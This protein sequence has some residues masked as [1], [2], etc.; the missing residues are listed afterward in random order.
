ML[1][2]VL[3]ILVP[4]VSTTL[5]AATRSA[6][7][8]LSIRS[9]NTTYNNT[10]ITTCH[11]GAALTS[12]C[13]GAH[14]VNL[15]EAAPFALNIV[16]TPSGILEFAAPTPPTTTPNATSTWFPM[17]FWFDV[18]TNVVMG[19][20]QPLS[21]EIPI[22]PT[23][24]MFDAGGLLV[25]EAPVLDDRLS[26][27]WKP[28]GNNATAVNRWFVCETWPPAAYITTSVVWGLGEAKPQNPSCVKVDVVKVDASGN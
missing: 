4:S 17:N 25:M 16:T 9:D 19:F 18:Y 6:P 15:T 22:Q 28:T 5:S 26:P 14:P 24:L 27:N 3:S 23:Q 11:Q 13:V 2:Y 21:A 7:F 1:L 10:A 12:L 8:H 20:F